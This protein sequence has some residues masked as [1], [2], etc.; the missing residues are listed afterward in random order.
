MAVETRTATQVDPAIQ[1]LHD[2]IIEA[3]ER[4]HV[5][6]VGLGVIHEGKEYLAGFGVTNAQAPAPVSGETLFQIGSTS[7][8]V[9][10]TG[11]MRLVDEGK[12][13]LDAPVRTYL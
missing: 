3:M 10:A 6:G 12:L 4:L 8:T 9:T 13:E 11:I 1:P 2:A 7:K 5:P